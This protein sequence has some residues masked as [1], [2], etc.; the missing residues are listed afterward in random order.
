MEVLVSLALLMAAVLFMT[1]ALT[2]SWEALRESRK[3]LTL[4]QA[5]NSQHHRLAS[6]PFDDPEL[7]PGRREWLERRP[8]LVGARWICDILETE[9]ALKRITLKLTLPDRQ[10]QAIFLKSKFILEVYHD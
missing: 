5:L 1:F 8:D 6:L 4:A 2:W 3:R 10:K 9:P 7:A